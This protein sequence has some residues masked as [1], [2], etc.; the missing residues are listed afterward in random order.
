MTKSL[1][2]DQADIL[3]GL[4]WVQTVCQGN[5]Q[6]TLVGKELITNDISS[7]TQ[8]RGLSYLSQKE[9]GIL[10]VYLIIKELYDFFLHIFYKK[11]GIS[12][13]LFVLL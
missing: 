5:K 7:K 13:T 12:V 11:L 2:P 4:I 1:D 9:Y 8:I 6:T 10:C 3:S